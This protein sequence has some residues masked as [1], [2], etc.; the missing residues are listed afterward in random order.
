MNELWLLSSIAALAVLA[1]IWRL[2]G[3][4][5][6]GR[7]LLAGSLA[8]GL[9]AL[10][11]PRFLVGDD[12]VEPVLVLMID[13]SLSMGPRLDDFVDLAAI[14]A[15][16][17]REVLV[18]LAGGR[19]FS[20]YH[21]P[22]GDLGRGLA[23]PAILADPP[24]RSRAAVG[25]A[26]ERAHE[27]LGDRAFKVVLVSDGGVDLPTGPQPGLVGLRL[28]PG[29]RRRAED[30]ALRFR[31][32]PP[33]VTGDRPVDLEL[34]VE[35]RL[36]AA[37]SIVI[38]AG[39]RRL[40]LNLPAGPVRED[41][42]LRFRPPWPAT[43]RFEAVLVADRADAQ[44]A[45][46]RARL[47]FLVGADEA[48]PVLLVQGPAGDRRLADLLATAPGLRLLGT[49][50][51]LGAA[52]VILIDSLSRP[53]LPWA[54]ELLEARVRSGT[55]LMLV[56]C[57]DA[58]G[59]GGWEGS[60]LDRLS[61]LKAR[62]G[63]KPR[64]LR[65]A[66][67]HSGSMAGGG[68]L[69]AAADSV[70]ALFQTLGPEDRLELILFADRRRTL[71]YDVADPGATERLAGDLK[72]LGASGGTEL[73][74]LLEEMAAAPVDP[75][76]ETLNVL[77]TDGQDPRGL[78]L[79]LVRGLAPRFA[80][81]GGLQL[82]WFDRDET[83]RPLLEILAGGAD[84]VH[85]VDDFGRLLDPYFRAL[86]QELEVGPLVL[87]RAEG[88]AEIGRLLRSRR[89][90]AAEILAARGLDENGLAVIGRGLGRV[91][92]A[93]VEPLPAAEAGLFG[94]GGPNA[95]AG[96]IAGLADR[97]AG[98][99]L[100]RL[101]EEGGER[102]ELRGRDLGL[103]PLRL[104]GAEGEIDLEPVGVDRARSGLRTRPLAPGRYHLIDGAGR[105]RGAL[106]LAEASWRDLGPEPEAG[107]HDL[108]TRLAALVAPG[109]TARSRPRLLAALLVVLLAIDLLLRS[110]DR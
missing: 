51:P 45:N 106:L 20:L 88:R 63:R 16:P 87:A 30:L 101:V 71:V 47:P 55:G 52:S 109:T 2:R 102:L 110:R 100:G 99:E 93:P 44:P 96:F 25:P 66:L 48:V 28:V 37:R 49:E 22:A 36:E 56:G 19:P 84:R 53:S 79:A 17:D 81:V 50:A 57:V 95:L 54:P 94:P 24:F 60:V 78:D 80:A 70:R 108:E 76:R 33:L 90:P 32:P 43:G 91:A 74:A 23:S 31:S 15:R 58:F 86:G 75:D 13:A 29:P 12:P 64:C 73:R 92:A 14:E 5:R 39:V 11:W 104:R 4:R 65:F 10:A 40:E 72:A 35:G 59:A 34:V 61:P 7:V 8:I 69:A 105:D 9:L 107:R 38:E 3:R 89:D 103:G 1:L 18:L 98:A 68:R 21:G 27:L 85:A 26:L 6:A 42:L 67:D 82:F 46:D 97:P 77:A 83:L 41:L 62:P